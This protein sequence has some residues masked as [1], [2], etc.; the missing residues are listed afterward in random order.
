M[1]SWILLSLFLTL[2][3]QAQTSE[4]A[5]AQIR[6]KVEALEQKGAGLVD[7]LSS[8]PAVPGQLK[9]LINEVYSLDPN[10]EK[11]ASWARRLRGQPEPPKTA[12][13]DFDKYKKLL[14]EKP[15]DKALVREAADY[16]FSVKDYGRAAVLYH[17]LLSLDPSAKGANARLAEIARNGG[18]TIT[19]KK[20][21]EAEA[22]IGQ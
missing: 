22:K 10:N 8:D 20:H 14:E 18:D 2:N 12:K 7:H 13:P 11:A 4:E 6:S 9:A 3:S 5:K 16:S 19:E 17:K 15:N 1:I 21:L